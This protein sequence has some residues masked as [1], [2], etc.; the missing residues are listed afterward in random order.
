MPFRLVS[1][2]PFPFSGL[3]LSK[4]LVI[5]FGGKPLMPAWDVHPKDIRMLLHRLSRHKCYL[6]AA[7]QHRKDFRQPTGILDY[8]L[9]C[10]L[11]KHSKIQHE[12]K[13]LVESH[14]IAQLVGCT[15]TRDR[16]FAAQLDKSDLCRFCGKFKESL[17]HLVHDCEQYHADHPPLPVHEYGPNFGC[18]GS[19]NILLES[20]DIDLTGMIPTRFCNLHSTPLLQR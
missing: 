19:L 2:K 20:L 1:H 16:I 10:G 7:N 14:F 17:S 3:Q 6:Q 11:R 5:S 8:E 18:W 13:P 12:S 4:G 15:L 9:S